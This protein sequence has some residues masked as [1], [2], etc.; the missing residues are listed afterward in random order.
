MHIY[1]SGSAE[2]WECDEMGHMNVRFWVRHCMDGVVG[3]AAAIGLGRAFAKGAQSTLIPTRQ[4]IKFLREA[5]AGAPLF[6]RSG[7][8]EVCET[9]LKLYSEIVHRFTGE[10]GAT[11]ITTLA[12]IEAH[13][14]RAFPFPARVR[15]L[16]KPLMI[17]LP[18]HGQPRSIAADDPLP[19]GG[20]DAAIALGL[21]A[22]GL[23]GVRGDEVDVFDRLYPE[24]MIGRVSNAMPNLMSAWREEAVQE[25]SA[26]D[27][28]ARRAGAAV[29]EYRLDYLAWPKAGDTTAAFSGL[30]D[31]GDKTMTL[32]HWLVDPILGQPWCVCA[33]LAVT[34]DLDA[35]KIIATPPLARKR[36]EAM[37]IGGG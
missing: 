15:E 32:Y 24:G 27:G 14:G 13:S 22:I 34:L 8:L 36:L 11:F 17:D 29:L 20:P 7:V 3:L 1:W 21:T 6:L 28:I 10:I 26:G 19:S 18:I 30:A 4:H 12:H 16:A 25:L 5:R 31:I 33:A 9:T 23:T 2:A 35:R 37:L